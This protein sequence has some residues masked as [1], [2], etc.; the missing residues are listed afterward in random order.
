MIITFCLVFSIRKNFVDIGA[1]LF[2]SD[3]CKKAILRRSFFQR[4]NNENNRDNNVLRPVS[5]TLALDSK[6]E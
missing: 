2:S 6:F 1:K 5:R 4:H 3:R